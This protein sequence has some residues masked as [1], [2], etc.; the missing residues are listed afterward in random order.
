MGKKYSE[1]HEGDARPDPMLEKEIKARLKG[2]AIPCAVVFHTAG[3]LNVTPQQIGKTADLLEIPISKCQL[4]LFGYTPE[5]KIV[6]AEKTS[7]QELMDAIK[8]SLVND[9]LPCEVAWKIAARFNAPKLK[10]G[11]ICEGEGIKVKPCQLG[12]F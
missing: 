1:K 3:E 11:N 10:I 7:N 4:G 6:K 2:Q 5:K 8:A 12:A 9:R